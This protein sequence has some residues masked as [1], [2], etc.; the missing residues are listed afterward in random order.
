M[1][2][3]FLRSFIFYSQLGVFAPLREKERHYT[4]QTLLDMA[5]ITYKNE[6][7]TRSFSNKNF[8]ENKIRQL[9]TPQEKVV[10]LD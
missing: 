9:L 1:E 6:D 10:N 5:N 7:L 4:F 8:D 3:L 2:I